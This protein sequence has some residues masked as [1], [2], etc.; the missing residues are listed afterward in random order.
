MPAA[1]L[2]Q[3]VGRAVLERMWTADR[4][5]RMAAAQELLDR[6]GYDLPHRVPVSLKHALHQWEYEFDDETRRALVR[7]ALIAV[8]LFPVARPDSD[9]EL[10]LCW[11]R[12]GAATAAGRKE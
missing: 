10:S 7:D 4:L 12:V 2:E 5:A 9:D 3:R 6:L 11:R 8:V 1:E